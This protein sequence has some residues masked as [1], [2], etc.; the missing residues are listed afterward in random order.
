MNAEAPWNIELIFVTL[1]IRH[2]A[3]GC[4]YDDAPLNIACILVTL[5]TFQASNGWSNDEAPANMQLIS[6]TFWTFQ[7]PSLRGNQI[8]G[9]PRHRCDVVL[10]LLSTLDFDTAPSGWLNDDASQNM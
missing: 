3:S 8:S 10:R 1:S 2:S 6:V 7:S 5:S 4:L 9:A